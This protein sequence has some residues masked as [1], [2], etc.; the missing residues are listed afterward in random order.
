MA[1]GREADATGGVKR[2]ELLSAA[3]VATA[4]GALPPVAARAAA[5]PS[6]P[7]A[8]TGPAAR[9][10]AF[11]TLSP[12]EAEFLTAAV[13]T[14]IPADA[15]S[16]SAS[17][18]GVVVFIDRQLA[19]AWGGGAR[20]YRSGPFVKGKPE[21]GYQLPLTPREY[22][23]AGIAAV[24]LWARTGFGR[25]LAALDQPTREA[26]LHRLERGEADLGELS[27][28]DFFEALLAITIEGFLADP[29]YG[30]NRDKAGW[31]MVGYPGLPATYANAVVRA[32]GQPF[33]PAPKS[34]EDFL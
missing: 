5:G 18:L 13:D 33:H 16:P 25:P 29:I 21:H 24:D 7:P 34:I 1:G 23:A 8:E 12:A 10:Q 28:R 20:L 17:D 32:K 26:A 27:P 9:P 2:R 30:G 14:L 19:G 31:K 3:F 11:L 22:F 15:L 4:T 6:A